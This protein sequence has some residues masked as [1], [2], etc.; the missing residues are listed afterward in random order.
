MSHTDRMMIRD[1]IFLNIQQQRVLDEMR[2]IKE[3]MQQVKQGG[4]EWIRLLMGLP[5]KDKLYLQLDKMNTAKIIM[6]EVKDQINPKVVVANSERINK[7]AR[8][9][10]NQVRPSEDTSTRIKNQNQ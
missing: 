7:S 8:S 3:K 1:L 5:T 9:S 6:D 4:P 2:E 10:R